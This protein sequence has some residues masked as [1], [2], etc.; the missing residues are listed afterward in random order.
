MGTTAEMLTKLVDEFPA[1]TGNLWVGVD[2]SP[3]TY[4]IPTNPFIRD[5]NDKALIGGRLTIQKAVVQLVDS[6]GVDAFLTTTGRGEYQVVDWSGRTLGR[7]SAE[8]G[9]QPISTNPIPVPIGRE[10]R[11]FSWRL[12]A[13]SW[14]PLTITA[15][16]WSG[17]LFY[18]ARRV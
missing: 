17:Q 12:R 5:Q 9:I 7:P 14:L 10:I 8:I 18:N 2:S 3:W 16:E 4:V 1:E 13:K 15:V 6:G 11:E